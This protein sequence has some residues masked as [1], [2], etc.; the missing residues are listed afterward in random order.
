[1]YYRPFLLALWR[2]FDPVYFEFTRLQHLC[3]ENKERGI[4]R[5]RL[6]RYRGKDVVLSDG[7]KISKNDLMLK[8]HL[9]NVKI[10]SDFSTMKNEWAKGRSIFRQVTD[11]MPLLAAFI[12]NHPQKNNIKGI[13]GITLINKGYSP[14]GFEC[15]HPENRFYSWFKKTL[16][17]PIYLLSSSKVS[18]LKKHHT[19]Y[20]MMSK[21]KL[22][23]KYKQLV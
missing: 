13:I 21:E 2:Y 22:M 11:S 15:Y 23:K 10:L 14:L 5:V 8:I 3:P 18:D 7:I 20:L 12:H 17:L 1:M 4:F 16:Q 9:H 6:T 19:V